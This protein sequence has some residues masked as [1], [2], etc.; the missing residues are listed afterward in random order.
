MITEPAT[1]GPA[2]ARVDPGA[3]MNAIWLAHRESVLERL[4]AL[5]RAVAEMMVGALSEESRREGEHEAH[6]LAGAV[7]TFGY[8]RAS[9]LA[10]EIE[11]ALAPNAEAETARIPALADALLAMRE[12]LEAE[13]GLESPGASAVD[14]D[15]EGPLVLVVDDDRELRARFAV[16]AAARSLRVEYADSPQA[17]RA[18][19]ARARPDVVLLDLSFPDGCDDA[20]ALCSEL[21]EASPPVAVLVFTVSDAFTDRVE[22]ARHGARGYLRKS[23]QAGEALDAAAAL[24]TRLESEATKVLAV[25]DDPAVLDALRAL[26]ESRGLAVTRLDDPARLWEVLEEVAPEL[27]ILDVDMPGVN[28]IDL[29][30]VVRNDPRWGA[31]PIMFLTARRDA[32]TV[33][34]IFAAGADDYLNK[35]IVGAELTTRVTNRLERIRLYRTLADIDPLTGVANRRK[36]SE[37]LNR[38]AVMATH[39]GQPLSVAEIDLD[40]FKDVNDRFGHAAGDAVLRRLGELLARAFRGEDVVA[41]WGGEE[42]I[43][44][45]YGM[46]RRDG[47]ARVADVLEG[48][49]HERFD[50]EGVTIPLSFSAGVAQYPDDGEDLQALYRAADDALYQ[51]KEA[52]RDRVVPAGWSA[53]QPGTDRVDVVVVEDDEAVAALLLHSLETRGLVARWIAEGTEAAELLSGPSPQLRG[54]VVLLDVDLPG[55]DGLAILR[56]LAQAGTLRRTRVVMLTARA[57]EPE[58][59]EALEVGAFDHVP[60]PFSVPV[61]MQKVRRALEA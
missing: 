22:V 60:K 61:L 58:I 9:E 48:F 36:S 37:G 28:G 6:K 39:Y 52:G 27:L 51:A 34:R 4:D 1:A 54:R 15:G 17:G 40:H 12:E 21:S 49:R 43:V 32:D 45:M 23:M 57:G 18:S 10:R 3:A 14:H 47:V 24:L 46:S 56:A 30:R 25:D 8:Q 50:A 55:L 44:G 31:L 59:L 33:Q 16:A 13:P 53:N 38:L 41:R 42:F 26:L 7:G 20:L 29:C 11:L 35:P 5:D 2:G 19:A